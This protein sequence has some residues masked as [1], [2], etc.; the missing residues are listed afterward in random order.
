MTRRRWPTSVSTGPNRLA[1]EMR[2]LGELWRHRITWHMYA[3]SWPLGASF[4]TP[5]YCVLELIH[6]QSFDERVP[7]VPSRR[8]TPRTRGP[9]NSQLLKCLISPKQLRDTE[10]LYFSVPSRLSSLPQGYCAINLCSFNYSPPSRD[11]ISGAVNILGC[12]DDMSEVENPAVTINLIVQPPKV[13]PRR[14]YFPAGQRAIHEANINT[15]GPKENRE[16]GPDSIGPRVGVVSAQL[17][18]ERPPDVG[19]S[20]LPD[21]SASRRGRL[22]C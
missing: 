8:L 3:I 10:R 9:Q 7:Q 6:G 18:H 11:S 1:Q 14:L 17:V 22:A 13:V 4:E 19:I 2:L 21:D 15:R 12:Y 20:H 5:P 16:L